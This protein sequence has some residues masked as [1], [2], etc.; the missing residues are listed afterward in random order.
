MSSSKFPWQEGVLACWSI[1]GMNHYHV[2]GQRFLFVSM[3]KDGRCITEEGPDDKYLWNRLFHKACQLEEK[4]C[5]KT[6]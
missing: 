2:A 1:C 4:A 6:P 3:T 5:A